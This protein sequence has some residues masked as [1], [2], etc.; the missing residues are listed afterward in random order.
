[1]EITKEKRQA[2]HNTLDNCLDMGLA[3]IVAGKQARGGIMYIHNGNKRTI[4]SLCRKLLG[5]Y[6]DGKTDEQWNEE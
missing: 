1:M 4:T 3:T 2:M 6:L 5:K